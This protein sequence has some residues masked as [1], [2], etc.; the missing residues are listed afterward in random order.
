MTTHTSEPTPF[1][2]A[3]LGYGGLVPFVGLS[4]LSWWNPSHASFWH[5]ALY[6]Y[7][8]V[9]LSFIG[10]LHWGVAMCAS[11]PTD[12]LRRA[13]YRWSVAPALIAWVALCLPTPLATVLLVVGYVAQYGR[14][15]LL[16][17]Q[18]TL[19][20]WYLPL[21][22]RLSSVAVLALLAGE[23]AMR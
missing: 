9:I 21:R 22:L 17:R 23:W 20:T 6:D 7:G 15:R 14:D 16:V 3:L 5:A 12:A 18:I 8:A 4:L 11:D 10:A 13:C 2:V 19:P 1:T